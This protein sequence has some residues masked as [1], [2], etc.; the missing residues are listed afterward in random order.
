MTDT[1]PQDQPFQEDNQQQQI[2]NLQVQQN[3][4]PEGYEEAEVEDQYAP[5]A[6]EEE[7]QPEVQIE[8]E[9]VDAGNRNLAVA[10]EPPK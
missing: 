5:N 4:Q 10:Q 8:V 1:I 6:Q 2:M 7:V 3:S 9:E